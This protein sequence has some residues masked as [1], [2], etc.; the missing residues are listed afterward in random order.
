MNINKGLTEYK[1][2]LK[3]RK[4]DIKYIK[5]NP[6]ILVDY[7]IVKK[8]EELYVGDSKVSPTQLKFIVERRKYHE[9]VNMEV[10]V[11]LIEDGICD[12]DLMDLENALKGLKGKAK[13]D[14][15]LS[16]L[17]AEYYSYT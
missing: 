2:I 4:S 9:F 17:C 3:F 7:G 6:K 10:G 5:D 1:T 16:F 13:E 12:Y 15:R 11:T 14:E 8:D